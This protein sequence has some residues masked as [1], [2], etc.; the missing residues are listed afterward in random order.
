MTAGLTYLRHKASL[1]IL[2]P[3]GALR[4]VSQ[5]SLKVVADVHTAVAATQAQPTAADWG[6]F[7]ASADRALL[8]VCRAGQLPV[9]KWTLRRLVTILDRLLEGLDLVEPALAENLTA[10]QAARI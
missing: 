9:T 5:T 6:T 3:E 10:P 2:P 8:A 4:R 7:R 1:V